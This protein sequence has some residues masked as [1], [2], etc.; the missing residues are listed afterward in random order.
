MRLQSYS[1]IHSNSRLDDI[2]VQEE[3]IR[4]FFPRLTPFLFPLCL[5][6]GKNWSSLIEGV[7]TEAR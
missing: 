7:A 4:D 5:E 6:S 3:L 2:L 1:H